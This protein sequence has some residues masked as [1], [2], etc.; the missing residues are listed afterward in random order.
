MQSTSALRRLALLPAAAAAAAVLA[1]AAAP[2][3]ALAAAATWSPI[4]LQVDG[5]P[6]GSVQGQENDGTREFLAIPYAAPP[7]GELRF[8]PPQP[9]TP[10]NSTLAGDTY[11]AGCSQLPT[12]T[13]SNVRIENEDCLYL[14]VWTPN[15]V[16]TKPLP[17]MV[18]FHGGS[19]VS[20]ST[21]DFVPFPDYETVR[22]YDGHTLSRTG[23]VIVVTVNYRLNAFGFF[24]L[25]E[26]ASEDPAY[27][28]AGNQGLLDQRA[29]LQ[30]VKENIAAFGGD[31]A[32]VTIFGESAGSFDVCAH[33]VSPMSAGLFHK[34][35]GQSGGCTV[36]VATAESAAANAQAVAEAVGC[37]SAA[38]KLAC[39]RAVPTADLLD[40]STVATGG[41]EFALS[42][43]VDGGFLPE[44]PRDVFNR[45]ELPKIP[46][47]LGAN[48]DEGT[49]FALNV[50]TDLTAEEYSA[51]LVAQYG[52][53]APEIEALYPTSKFASPRDALVRVT[54]DSTLVCSTY[55]VA[56]RYSQKG[57]K[58]YAYSFARV[59]A[60]PFINVLNL[61]A[62]HG[63][64]LG[65]VFGSVAAA[66]PF[67]A[68]LST[69]MQQY[70]ASFATSAKPAA[71]FAAK[72]APFKAKTWKMARLNVPTSAISGWR[73]AECDYWSTVYDSGDF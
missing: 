2:G 31:P 20:G 25:S 68:K 43:S 57:R 72:W 45:N 35:I 18:W 40:A 66:G 55:D 70:W 17:V 10:W 33:M 62:F 21:A 63:L 59:P 9:V 5:V 53:R 48:A 65:Y 14:N 69:Q 36:G 15:P 64:E 11:P 16:P 71:A 32:N 39:L 27:P 12:L 54:G 67:D 29:S 26:L 52:S 4:Q 44:H 61:G 37:G 56:R 34:A 47:M 19:N 23:N 13:N 1:V 8:S 28:Y 73:K 60:L 3:L 24:G 6:A 30:W 38:D 58:V 41:S 46:Y 42:L 49:L 7:V 51:E 22:L 50:P